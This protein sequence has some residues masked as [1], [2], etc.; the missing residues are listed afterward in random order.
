MR[1][2]NRFRREAVT[3][4]VMQVS[5]AGIVVCAGLL[6]IGWCL[7]APLMVALLASF[8]FGSTAVVS[9]AALGGSSPLIFT[10]LAL[11]LLLSIFVRK[12]TFND[13]VVVFMEQRAAWIV[14]GLTFYVCLSAVLLPRL[15]AGQTAAFVPARTSG[16]VFEVPLAPVPGNVTQTCY[17]A[18]GALTFLALSVLL[19]REA[20]LEKIRRGFLAWCVLHAGLGLV[21]IVSKLAGAGDILQP[22]RTAAYALVTDVEEAGFS[23]IAGGYSEASGFGV[24]TLAA[25]A[26]AFTYWRRTRSLPVL[27]LAIVLLVLLMLCTSTTAYVGLAIVSIPVIIALTR[28]MLAGRLA[29][30]DLVLLALAV[31]AVVIVLSIDLYD[32]HGFSPVVQLFE[33]TILNKPLSASAQERAYW[34]MKSLQSFAD[35]LGLGIGFGS[36]RSSSWIIAVVSQIGL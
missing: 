27:A 3:D 28:S 36:S 19:L 15:F 20:N 18:L 12:A 30:G 13:L 24:A 32:E 14:F 7:R 21:D 33:S 17:F 8:A 4:D 29:R 16:R 34:N 2:S 25:L 26:F 11:V 22:I 23:R 31:F 1:V 5:L 10:V 35:T 9:L 6:L